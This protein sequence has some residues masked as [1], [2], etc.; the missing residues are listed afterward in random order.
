MQFG[1]VKTLVYEIFNL[2]VL[3]MYAAG[4]GYMGAKSTFNST[5]V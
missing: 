2:R 1:M 3:P 5:W 4:T